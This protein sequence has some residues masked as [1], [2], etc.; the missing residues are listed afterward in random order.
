MSINFQKQLKCIGV[1]KNEHY[2]YTSYMYCPRR[3]LEYS[4]GRSFIFIGMKILHKFCFFHHINTITKPSIMINF[5]FSQK[6]K[7]L[8]NGEFKYLTLKL[9]LNT[10]TP[11]HR[12]CYMELEI[13]PKAVRYPCQHNMT[14]VWI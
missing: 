5:Q 4:G 14:Q 2:Y 6:F 1:M 9:Y 13:D 3:C 10:I 11:Q 7:L 12:I 8:G